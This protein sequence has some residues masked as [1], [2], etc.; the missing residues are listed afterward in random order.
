MR[1]DFS[2]LICILV[3]AFSPVKEA[4]GSESGDKKLASCE[5]RLKDL[6][7][8]LR[9]PVGISVYRMFNVFPPI[10][11]GEIDHESIARSIKSRVKSIDLA[12]HC[13]PERLLKSAMWYGPKEMQEVLNDDVVPVRVLS[14]E[15]G[16]FVVFLYPGYIE[17]EGTGTELAAGVAVYKKNGEFLQVFEGVSSWAGNEGTLLMRE[18]C[19]YE[20]AI[21]FSYRRFYPDKVTE[22]GYVVTYDLMFDISKSMRYLFSSE[23]ALQGGYECPGNSYIRVNR[24]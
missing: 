11:R 21:S 10:G 4:F 20:E 18:S 13:F 5:K 22:D 23:D 6:S 19:L 3:V 15:K 16:Y 7:V 1:I 14:G 17:S 9:G 8:A 12:S 24:K 2:L